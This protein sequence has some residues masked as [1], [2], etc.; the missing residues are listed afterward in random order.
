LE[1]CA[2]GGVNNSVDGFGN[3]AARPSVIGPGETAAAHLD[4]QKS[5][6]SSVC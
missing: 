2:Q 4:K 3:Y 5:T 6:C 1:H